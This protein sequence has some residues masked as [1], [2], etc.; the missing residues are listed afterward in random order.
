MFVWWRLWNAWLVAARAA[1][2]GPELWVE[3]DGHA[4]SYWD[5]WFAVVC[6]VDHDGDWRALE[7]YLAARPTLGGREDEERLSHL[8]D[9]EER[10]AAAGVTAVELVGDSIADPK[11]R[12]RARSKVVKQSMS[13]PLS[14]AMRNTPR[15]GLRAR[16]LRGRWP[17][18]PVDPTPFAD[19]VSDI[20][21]G[22]G[23][24]VRR[25]MALERWTNDVERR[26]T[27][28]AVRL[29]ARRGALAAGIEAFGEGCATARVR[30]RPHSARCSA[31]MPARTGVYRA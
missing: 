6:V 9:V 26:H 11:V 2:D 15:S 31:P 23:G 12:E 16:A 29:A 10:L 30:W 7:Q 22:P 13:G 27:D 5:R 25:A 19:A 8:W 3:R 14:P 18:F 17:E 4:W 21:E 24:S 20:L 1:I 28:V